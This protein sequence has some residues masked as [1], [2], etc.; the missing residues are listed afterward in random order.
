MHSAL[1]LTDSGGIQEEGVS[2]GR[3]VLVLREKTE[4]AEGLDSGFLTIVGTKTSEIVRVARGILGSIPEKGLPETLNS[5]YG[6]GLAAKR[7]AE[8]VATGKSNDWLQEAQGLMS[9]QNK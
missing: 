9:D 1:I 5:T 2:L 6:D 7:I 3:Q 4:R 8:A